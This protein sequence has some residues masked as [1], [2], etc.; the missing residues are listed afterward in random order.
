MRGRR[1]NRV[2]MRSI[3]ALLV[4]LG[5]GGIA[6]AGILDVY[7][8]GSSLN[9]TSFYIIHQEGANERY[10]QGEDGA[11]LNPMRP[12]IEISSSPYPYNFPLSVDIKNKE[13]TLPIDL[14]CILTGTASAGASFYFDITDANGYEHRNLTIQEIDPNNPD[15]PNNLN[16][17]Y[18]IR[19][20]IQNHEG[21]L[22]LGTF[23]Q[24]VVRMFRIG[25]YRILDGDLTEN[26]VVDFNDFAVFGNY[27][28]NETAEGEN[29]NISDINHDRL[30]DESDLLFF[31]DT[32]L[33]EE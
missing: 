33:K 10:V 8:W 32:W 1:N 20:R 23:Q 24:D 11:L 22:P 21:I 3:L 25:V 2:K 30:T 27:W 16:P 29:L 31:V 17:I 6:K 12:Y 19:D 7:I 9:T 18:N 13:S 5:S 26:G 14:S 15:D 4:I 28:L